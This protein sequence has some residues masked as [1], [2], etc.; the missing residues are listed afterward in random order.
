[1]KQK[2]K[3]LCMIIVIL[4]ILISIICLYKH[5]HEG[6]ENF[7][8]K[9]G[10]WSPDG[11]E[12]LIVGY[13]DPYTV[14]MRYN[15]SEFEKLLLVQGFR[16]WNVYW[17]PD[18][19]KAFILGEKLF[20]Y[21]KDEITE[22]NANKDMGAIYWSPNSQQALMAVSPQIKLGGHHQKLMRFDG[23]QFHELIDD[24]GRISTIDW[25]F[26]GDEAIILSDNYEYVYRNDNVS[27]LG[28]GASRASWNPS[29]NFALI[30]SSEGIIKY[31]RNRTQ[32][33][34]TNITFTEVYWNSNGTEALLIDQSNSTSDIEWNIFRNDSIVHI[35]DDS[36]FLLSRGNDS[37]LSIPDVRWSEDKAII[38]LYLREHWYDSL[39]DARSCILE[40]KNN[41]IS[42]ITINFGEY[43]KIAWSPEGSQALIMGEYRENKSWYPSLLKYRNNN[44]EGTNLSMK[45]RLFDISWNEKYGALIVGGPT[46]V[47]NYRDN[48]LIDLSDE[49]KNAL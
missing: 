2:M 26:D 44:I 13:S 12:A 30:S 29:S 47:Y 22:I 3:I 37:I 23:E 21:E 35:S 5:S 19:S 34:S 31:N 43:K 28:V 38:L 7:W 42:L 36:H 11:S 14:I 4:L 15:G 49:F 33:I 20:L 25:S 24:T 10:K 18:S 41:H 27:N 39:E 17:S 45:G 32:I 6:P 1:M 9:S 46:I 40:Y 16:L 8:L 48:K